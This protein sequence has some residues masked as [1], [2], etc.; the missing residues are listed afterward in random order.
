M[1]FDS[2]LLFLIV[3]AIF[4]PGRETYGLESTA[5]DSVWHIHINEVLYKVSGF[6]KASCQTLKPEH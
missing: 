6:G 1:L 5:I 4:P 2:Y 3:G